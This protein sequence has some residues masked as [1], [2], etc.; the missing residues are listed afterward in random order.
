MTHLIMP[1]AMQTSV[2]A[3]VQAAADNP[4]QAKL[5]SYP[6][7]DWLRFAFA[8]FVLLGHSDFAGYIL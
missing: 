3:S 2:Q 8:S 4:E 6:L 5:N 7:F 1:D